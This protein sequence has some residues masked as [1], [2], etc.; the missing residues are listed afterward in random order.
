[1]QEMREGARVTEGELRH[2]H[3]L[4][5]IGQLAAGIAHEINSPMQYIGDNA[6]FLKSAFV[7]L[8]EGLARTKK[9]CLEL[10]GERATADLLRSIFDELH[11]EYLLEQAPKALKGTLEGVGRVTTIVP[12]LKDFA[13]PHPRE[14]TSGEITHLLEAALVVILNHSQ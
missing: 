6:Q 2:S 7:D 4:E 1:M 10:G 13:H 5:A 14:K 3:K 9:L 8:C 11:I 12:A